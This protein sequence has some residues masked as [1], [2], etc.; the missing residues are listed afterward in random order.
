LASGDIGGFSSQYPLLKDETIKKWKKPPT[1]IFGILEE[2]CKQL[3][4]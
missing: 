3:S 4:L 1:L 2:E